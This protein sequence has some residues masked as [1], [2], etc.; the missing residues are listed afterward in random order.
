MTSTSTAFPAAS[1]PLVVDCAALH[2]VV[3]FA[4]H[5]DCMFSLSGS[6]TSL[7]Y[8]SWPHPQLSAVALPCDSVVE[9]AG[10]KH[11]VHALAPDTSAN[12]PARQLVHTVALLAPVTPEYFPARQLVHTAALLAPVTPEY[13]PAR[14]FVQTVSVLAPVTPEYAPAGQAMHALD[15]GTVLYWPAAHAGHTPPSGPVYPA[16]QEQAAIPEL[17]AAVFAFAGHAVHV[18]EVFAPTAC[19]YVASPQS[20]HAALP[21][22]I[23]YFPATHAAQTPPSAPVLPALQVQAA[24][25]EPPA[26][27]FA[28]AGHCV[29]TVALLAPA[30]VEYVP[31]RQRVQL[32]GP[33]AGLYVPAAHAVHRPPL[34]PVYPALHIQAPIPELNTGEFVFTGHASHDVCI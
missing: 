4:P 11:V 13:V 32:L 20:T 26:G 30:T 8:V 14:Q 25:D 22:T 28:P 16:L 18:D 12:A 5:F 34:G 6:T 23:L 29:Q 19:E 2:T 17:D 31:A 10:E 27:E 7:V 3:L 21:V 1:V 33:V 15:P 9:P 24:P